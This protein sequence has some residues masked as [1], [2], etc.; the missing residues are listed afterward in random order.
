MT[1][2]NTHI[3]IEY[4][5]KSNSSKDDS[6]RKELLW[7]TREEVVIKK[8]IEEM[9]DQSKKHYLAGKKN[10]K[11]HE[12]ITLP[13]III[14]V[15]AS[16]LT[17]LLQ[18]YVYVSTGL[19]LTVGILNGINGFINPAA[20]KEKHLNYEGLYNELV[21]DIEKELCKPKSMRIACDVYLEQIS[22]KKANL[23]LS[24]PLL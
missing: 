11:L 9:K 17:P 8:W 19:M 7:E 23:D 10:K 20:K 18:P 2:S 14:P 6:Q 4:D 13:S 5:D 16:G 12:F 15:I 1:G 21:L 24:A 22:L 3:E